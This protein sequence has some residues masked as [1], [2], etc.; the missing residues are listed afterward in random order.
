M[1]RPTLP[2]LAALLLSAALL[3]TG[4]VR[5][6]QER[7]P[8]D[9]SSFPRTS[10]QIIHRASGQPPH[11]YPFDVWVADTP[12][13]AQQGLMF[14]RDLPA[15]M[16]MIFPLDTPRVETMWMKNTYIPLDMVFIGS[17]G[18]ISKILANATPLSEQILTSDLPVAAVLELRGGEAAKL[19]LR[20]GDTVS[21]QK[22]TLH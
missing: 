2:R 8:E 12:Q 1:T 19:D 5:A 4:G 10:L 13:R 6:Q 22:P 20:V 9:L 17:D 21:W 15:T 7:A 18:R 14:V 11:S 3:A 16:G